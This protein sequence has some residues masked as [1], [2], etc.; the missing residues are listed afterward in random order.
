MSDRFAHKRDTV[1]DNQRVVAGIE[2]ALTTDADLHLSTRLRRCLCHQYTGHT[3]LQC[4]GSILGNDLVQ[5]L[6]AHIGDRTRNGLTTLRTIAD[7]DHLIEAASVLL[8]R[9]VEIGV[10]ANRHFLL[11]ISYIRNNECS[12]RFDVER[13][14]TVEIGHRSILST[15]FHDGSTNK[16]AHLVT[17]STCNPLGLL[18]SLCHTD[19]T[20][21]SSLR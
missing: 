21:Q 14:V 2:R 1:Q 15:F 16:C 7:D 17:D 9:D 10:A 12:T 20:G 18:H 11:I 4:F 6:T 3:S 19:I 13:E 5:V 8:E